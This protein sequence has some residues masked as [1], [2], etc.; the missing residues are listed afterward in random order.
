MLNFNKASVALWRV[1]FLD[2]FVVFANA[3]TYA[4]FFLH[5]SAPTPLFLQYFAVILG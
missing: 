2:I 5:F 1:L 3:G 4:V